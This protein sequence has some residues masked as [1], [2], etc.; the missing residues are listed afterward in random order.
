MATAKWD[1]ARAAAYG[2]AGGTVYGVFQLLSG[3]GPAQPILIYQ[4]T[5]VAGTALAGAVTFAVVAALRN[6][7]IR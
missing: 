2:A 3:A 1:T 4:L 5:F 7:I 6:L